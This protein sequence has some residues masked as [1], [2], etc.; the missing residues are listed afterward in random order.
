MGLGPELRLATSLWLLLM[1]CKWQDMACNFNLKKDKRMDVG[2]I[3]VSLGCRQISQLVC[4]QQVQMQAAGE[5]CAH[6]YT[7]VQQPLQQIEAA[8]HT[9]G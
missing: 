9:R 2:F 5:R 6:C 3:T 8:N 7:C 4:D 1:Y